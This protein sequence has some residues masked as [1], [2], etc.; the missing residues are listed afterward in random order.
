[1][2]IKNGDEVHVSFLSGRSITY[3]DVRKVNTDINYSMYQITDKWNC[4][5]F[6]DSKVIEH[7]EFGRE[8][9]IVEH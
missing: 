2:N 4:K 9:E 1:M 6:I 3:S 8:V 7:I 5:S